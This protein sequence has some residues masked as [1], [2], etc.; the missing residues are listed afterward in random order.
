MHEHNDN[1]I[2][3]SAGGEGLLCSRVVGSQISATWL[4][5]SL[6]DLRLSQKSGLAK[7]DVGY[8]G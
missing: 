2:I 1:R 6:I 8:F 7:L 5:R 4:E 3:W